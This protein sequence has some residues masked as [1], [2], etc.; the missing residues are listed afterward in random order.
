MEVFFYQVFCQ[1]ESN[2]FNSLQQQQQ[3]QQKQTENTPRELV[4]IFFQQ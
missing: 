4:A 1:A 3:Q 2:P